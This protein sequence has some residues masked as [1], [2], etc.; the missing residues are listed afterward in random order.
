MHFSTVAMMLVV[1]HV[2]ISIFYVYRWRGRMRYPSFSQYL[3]KSWPVFAPLNCL[4]YLS[5]RRFA[6]QPVL[7]AGFLDGIATLRQHWPRIRDEAVA[8]HRSGA[9]DATTVP[10]AAGY[11]DVGFRTFYRRGWKKFYLK[12]YGEPHH[13]ARQLC[14][15]TVRLLERV[16]C[17][18]AAMFSV[19][20]AGS[21][22][23]LHSDPMACSLRYH[24]GLE[25]PNSSRCFIC[26]DG[27]RMTWR[28]GQDFV[29]DE[30]YPHYAVNATADSRLILMCDVDRPMNLAGRALNLLYS[31]V[32]RAMAVP[33]TPE[34][35][36]GL[37]TRLFA[38]VAPWRMAAVALKGRRRGAYRAMKLSLNA[39]LVTLAFLLVY[40]VL[41]LIDQV[42]AAALY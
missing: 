21:E 11:H 33:N 20:P 42:D 6:R 19:L 28:D 5:T 41:R 2:L 36:R 10:G 35:G 34:D 4:L 8:L 14:P 23:S 37:L 29:F 26:V 25:T 15:E 30:T 17:I 39:T 18:R 24:L 32:A 13:S 16:P 31:Q 22:L 1:A 12:W 40:A 7:D 27:R 38:K 9:L 3:R